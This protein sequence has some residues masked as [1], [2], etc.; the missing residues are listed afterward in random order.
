MR[1][2][3]LGL[4]VSITF[5]TLTISA[6]DDKVARGQY[7]VE[8]VARCQD[9]HTPHLMGSGDIV[10]SAWLKGA[11]L[12]FVSRESAAELALED[13]GSHFHQHSCGRAGATMEW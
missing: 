10:K 3:F 4:A 9:C 6:Q 11:T 1:K 8:Q 5:L 13:A 2:V 12:D 7:L